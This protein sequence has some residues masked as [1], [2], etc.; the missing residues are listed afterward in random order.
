MVGCAI[1]ITVVRVL[2]TVVVLLVLQ[3]ADGT[4][5]ASCAATNVLGHALELV[6][7]LLTA[8]QSTALGLELIHSHS[9][10]GGGVVVSRLVMVNLMDRDSSVDNVRLNDLLLD[11]RLNGL[12]NVLLGVSSSTIEEYGHCQLT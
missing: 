6:V 7:T 4:E 1:V 11:D 9:R 8:S 5:A 12:V 3:A 2:L 10:Q